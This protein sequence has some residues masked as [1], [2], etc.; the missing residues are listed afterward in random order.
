MLQ[1]FLSWCEETNDALGI[2]KYKKPFSQLTEM[3]YLDLPNSP[4]TY[5]K[6]N[7]CIFFRNKHSRRNQ[8]YFLSLNI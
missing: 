4:R 7:K 2:A 6:E 1:P 8:Y 5:H 3:K